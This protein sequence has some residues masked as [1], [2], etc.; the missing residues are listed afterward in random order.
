MNDTDL[1]LKFTGID[2]SLGKTLAEMDKRLATMEKKTKKVGNTAKETAKKVDVGFKNMSD[3]FTRM[4]TRIS[5]GLTG[6]VGKA[7]MLLGAGG[8]IGVVTKSISAV[9]EFEKALMEVSTLIKGDAS[10]SI[11]KYEKHL[12]EMARNSSKD[13]VDLTKGLYQV[14]SAGV[15]GTETV[16]GSMELLNSSMKAGVAGLADTQSTVDILTTLLNAYGESADKATEYS[17]KLFTTVRL[18]KTTF[19][20]LASQLGMVASIAAGAGVKFSEIAAAMVAMTKGGLSTDIATTSLRATI[21]SLMKPS[22]DLKK[23]IKEIG[24]SSVSTML[25]EEGFVGTMAKLKEITGGNTEKLQK[26]IPNVRALAG[27]AIMAGTGTDSM[28][29]ALKEMSDSAGATEEAYAKMSETFAEKSAKFGN[30]INDILIE[31]GQSLLPMLLEKMGELKKWIDQNGKEIAEWVK[32]A[33]E[34]IVEFGTW[35]MNNA[36][37][38]TGLLAA[39][40]LPG[41][42]IGWTTALKNAYT[43]LKSFK[44]LLTG[45]VAKGGPLG[46]FVVGMGAVVGVFGALFDSIR[47][48]RLEAKKMMDDLHKAYLGID[49]TMGPGRYNP[50]AVEAATGVL[51]K[52]T[53]GK[54]EGDVTASLT[55]VLRQIDIAKAALDQKAKWARTAEGE[56]SMEATA[57]MAYRGLHGDEED[58]VWTAAM[59][60]KVMQERIKSEKEFLNEQALMARASSEKWFDDYYTL[61]I[62]VKK[63]ADKKIDKLDDDKLKKYLSSREKVEQALYRL[64][65]GHASSMVKVMMAR[66]KELE[67]LAAMKNVKDVERAEMEGLIRLKYEKMLAKIMD[68]AIAKKKAAH[69][70]ELKRI[71]E[72]AKYREEKLDFIERQLESYHEKRIEWQIIA[73]RKWGAEETGFISSLEKQL[74]KL[75]DWMDETFDWD[76]LFDS[77][78][79]FSVEMIG[80]MSSAWTWIYEKLL[81]QVQQ[82]FS[83]AIESAG[84]GALQIVLTSAEQARIERELGR[85]LTQDE[86]RSYGKTYTQEEL[87][88]LVASGQIGEHEVVG[89]KSPADIVGEILDKFVSWWENLVANLDGVMDWLVTEAIPRLVQAFIDA[90]PAI[91]DSLNKAFVKFMDWLSSNLAGILDA[92]LNE[93]PGIIMAILQGI[94]IAI[95]NILGDLDKIIDS[96]VDF[97]FELVTQLVD[98]I[99]FLIVEGIPE[100]V[101]TIISKIPEIV[102][103]I[104]EG[105]FVDLIPGLA[106]AIYEGVVKAFEDLMSGDVTGSK[107]GDAALGIATGG[108]STLGGKMFHDGGMIT[109]MFSDFSNAVKAHSGMFVKAP[110]LASDEVPIIA[111]VGEAVLSRSG[112][113]AAGGEA[114][115]NALNKGKSSGNS[116]IFNIGH[117][118]AESSKEVIDKMIGQNLDDGNGILNSKLS[119][120]SVSGFK[121]RRG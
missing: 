88:Q 112:V 29:T 74:S 58:F 2:K 24:Y 72:E 19:P 37:T 1:F 63:K 43:A 82:L 80:T 25:A 87:A 54:S 117:M 84:S 94:F 30:L 16:A 100:I 9:K 103:S 8:F 92:I 93:L 64:R 18:G 11:A 10:K 78:K 3:G 59:G 42:I 60:R 50:G 56:A 44:G 91:V 28:K 73:A 39:L 52:A 119:S 17:D 75:G 57:R 66:D 49:L 55:A 114:G 111:Q 36:A 81:G 33:M 14:I 95:K 104:V 113:A 38:I 116:F 118:F 69:D 68:A 120:G 34:S 15:K 26:L 41:K 99:I 27:V 83:Q 77:A 22:S 71:A 97:I 51:G 48:S 108:L 45:M 85:V 62:E 40:W 61:E 32:N 70:E 101:A 12:R 67:N 35:V 13:I 110:S 115:I 79:E 102:K 89:T 109:G 107:G 47:K 105:I 86:K 76:N 5:R 106:E 65:L 31:I 7:T 4:S 6:M 96:V 121:P 46:L 23:V 53:R 90:L 20:A 98:F 21:I